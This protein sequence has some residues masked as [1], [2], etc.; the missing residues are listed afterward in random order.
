MSQSSSRSKFGSMCNGLAERP[1]ARCYWELAPLSILPHFNDINSLEGRMYGGRPDWEIAPSI[2]RAIDGPSY[3]QSSWG[4]R[5]RMRSRQAR[6]S[7]P[8]RGRKR[9][10]ASLSA[11]ISDFEMRAIFLVMKGLAMFF[12]SQLQSAKFRFMRASH[13]S[14]P[15]VTHGRSPLFLPTQRMWTISCVRMATKASHTGRRAHG[16]DFRRE[17]HSGWPYCNRA[18]APRRVS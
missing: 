12:Q 1:L 13:V 6:I 3:T 10:N 18:D 17:A 8:Y 16:S 4:D 9:V 15:G 14:H 11:A 7:L 5:K 2:C